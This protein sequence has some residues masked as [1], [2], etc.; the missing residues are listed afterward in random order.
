MRNFNSIINSIFLSFILSMCCIYSNQEIAGSYRNL[1]IINGQKVSMA[2]WLLKKNFSKNSDYNKDKN[3]PTYFESFKMC[4]SLSK[5]S[6]IVPF[7]ITYIL[8]KITFIKE[9]S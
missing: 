9:T 6:I 3:E 5:S 2:I 7:F 1:I 4:T 8:S